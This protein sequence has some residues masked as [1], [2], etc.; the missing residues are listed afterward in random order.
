M[1]RY[2]KALLGLAIVVALGCLAG[3]ESGGDDGDEGA[4]SVAPLKRTLAP[5]EQARFAATVVPD[6][7]SQSVSWSVREAG[8]GTITATGLYTAPATT[9]TYHVDAT[10]AADRS[11]VASATVTVTNSTAPSGWIY[12]LMGTQGP[13]SQRIYRVRPD[14]SGLAALTSALPILHYSIDP[15]EQKVVWSGADRNLYTM[16]INGTSL[17][18]LIGLGT[19]QEPAWSPG[20]FRIAF[21][22]YT[23]RGAE[24][25]DTNTAGRD[26][27]QL[28]EV[29][30]GYSAQAPSY[31]MDGSQIAFSCGLNANDSIYL[32]TKNGGATRISAINAA[33]RYQT[34]PVLNPAGDLLAYTTQQWSSLS[35]RTD[36]GTMN[37]SGGAQTRLTVADSESG[38]SGHPTWSPTGLHMAY[39]SARANGT[40]DLW[41]MEPDGSSPRALGVNN[42]AQITVSHPIWR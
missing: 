21:I 10:S 4:I 39:A 15:A 36:I 27:R 26:L 25:W 17:R 11:L 20:G 1:D 35:N 32:M 13:L 33:G 2:P 16:N 8:G 28:Y 31:S 6:R 41:V 40:W 24:V 42:N 3:C 9:G 30:I 5:L 14:G 19:D 7:L 34:G 29:P 37:T 23:S 38:S 22:R 18:A 12:F